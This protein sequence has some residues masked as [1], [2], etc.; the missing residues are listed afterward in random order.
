MED[1]P[2]T[3]TRVAMPCEPAQHQKS[4]QFCCPTLK[5]QYRDHFQK[6]KTQRLVSSETKSK[7]CVRVSSLVFRGLHLLC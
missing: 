1:C 3:K 2:P 4:N 5:G 6:K 7:Q